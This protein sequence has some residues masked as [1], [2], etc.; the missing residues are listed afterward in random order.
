MSQQAS[1]EISSLGSLENSQVS[2]I[3]RISAV[4]LS[5]VNARR[6]DHGMLRV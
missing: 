2:V 5:S 4:S 3:A 1:R 6:E